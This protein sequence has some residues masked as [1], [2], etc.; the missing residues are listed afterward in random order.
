MYASAGAAS[1][2]KEARMHS[3]DFDFDVITGP[4]VPDERKPE[5]PTTPAPA[6]PASQKPAPQR[7]R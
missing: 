4:S 2:L 5:A 7:S 1:Q 3:S 6:Q